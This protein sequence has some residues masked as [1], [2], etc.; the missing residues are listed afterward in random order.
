MIQIELLLELIKYSSLG[1]YTHDLLW[2]KFSNWIFYHQY[3]DTDG[4]GDVD[5]VW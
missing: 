4:G 2:Q 5:N 1:S 3:L